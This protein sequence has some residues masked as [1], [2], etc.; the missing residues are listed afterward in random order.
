M[1]KWACHHEVEHKK[2][3]TYQ[4]GHEFLL[5]EEDYYS[6]KTCPF[7][8]AAHKQTYEAQ[9]QYKRAHVEDYSS[10]SFCTIL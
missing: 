1:K 10:S 2:L 5:C 8:A 4:C 3:V 6:F 9:N 7:H